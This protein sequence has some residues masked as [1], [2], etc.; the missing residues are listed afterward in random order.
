MYKYGVQLGSDI[1][2][3]FYIIAKNDIDLF[4]RIEFA[5]PDETNFFVF[6]VEKVIKN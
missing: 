2:N 5:F 4:K 1:T 3:P 6:S